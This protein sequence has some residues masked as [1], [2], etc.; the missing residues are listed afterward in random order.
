MIR[1]GLWDFERKITEVIFHHIL[2]QGYI[3]LTL[4]WH[5]VI[6]D[7]LTEIVLVGFSAVKLL[8]HTSLWKEVTLYNA[9]F[10]MGNYAPCPQGGSI[11]IKYLKFYRFV[12]FLSIIYL[13]NH[14]YHCGYLG[15]Y[16][17]QWV[18]KKLLIYFIVQLIL[19][20][21]SRNCFK[22]FTFK[23]SLPHWFPF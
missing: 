11:Y 19:P 5:D 3:L 13:Y 16:F 8:F 4:C 14:P 22:C 17:I 15:I 18:I 21:S 10:R 20:L 23:Y 7:C 12:Y 1:V 2:Y 6:I 9:H